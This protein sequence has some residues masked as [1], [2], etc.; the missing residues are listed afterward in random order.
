MVIEQLKSNLQQVKTTSL[1]RVLAS[2]ICNKANVHAAYH[3][4]CE[5]HLLARINV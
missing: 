4:E 5:L 1:I 3:F 2:K